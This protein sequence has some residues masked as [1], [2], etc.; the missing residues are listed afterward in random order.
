MSSTGADT[1]TNTAGWVSAG[2]DKIQISMAAFAAGNADTTADNAAVDADGAAIAVNIELAVVT[3]NVAD[4]TAAT[5]AT[6]VGGTGWTWA[7]NQAAGT[8]AILVADDGADTAVFMFT[9]A[10]ADAT[11]LA[12]ELTLIGFFSGVAATA[13]AD[14]AFIA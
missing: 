7:A 9:S 2:N 12:G 14:Y 10:A 8:K 11:I 6:V 4:I 13:V 5:A 1:I 3:N